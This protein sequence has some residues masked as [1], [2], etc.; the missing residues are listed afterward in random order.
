[1][2]LSAPS[3]FSGSTS[4]TGKRLKTPRY[5]NGLSVG[6]VW[7]GM[8]AYSTTGIIAVG[9]QGRAD[10]STQYPIFSFYTLSTSTWSTPATF[11]GFTTVNCQMWGVITNGTTT[12]VAVGQNASGVAIASVTTNGTTWTTPAVINA[13]LLYS[14]GSECITYSSSGFFVA[15]GSGGT[16]LPPAIAY[17]SNGTAWTLVTTHMS[18]S[19]GPIKSLC[20]NTTTIM[21]VAN[22]G[23]SNPTPTV[24]TG[25]YSSLGTTSTAL[26]GV[27][28][29]SFM[30]ANSICYGSLSGYMIVGSTSSQG[31]Y[32]WLS[33]TY[34]GFATAS[35]AWMPN[36]LGGPAGGVGIENSGLWH[37]FHVTSV[38]FCTT[39]ALY[40]VTGSSQM[41]SQEIPCYAT[42]NGT[43]W[44]IYPAGGTT[45]GYAE[46]TDIVQTSSGRLVAVGANYNTFYLPIYSTDNGT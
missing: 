39:L 29:F 45:G 10:L 2:L 33:T 46:L 35:I 15:G 8:C 26:G 31:G 24:G 41:N 21:A 30:T 28:P 40:V 37:T 14:S 38:R 6:G 36:N 42:F 5:S 18:T 17:S 34:A 16:F 20:A 22:L 3:L 23:G 12:A 44:N 32:Y 7:N 1:M 27:I 4:G 9:Y 13:A 11:N 25:T 43:T 19:N